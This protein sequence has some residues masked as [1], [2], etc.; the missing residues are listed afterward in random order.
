MATKETLENKIN[1]LIEEIE[2]SKVSEKDINS[3][4]ARI[5]KYF[6]DT[7]DTQDNFISKLKS[8]AGQQK[9]FVL[10]ANDFKLTGVIVDEET[11]TKCDADQAVELLKL[12]MNELNKPNKMQSLTIFNI[13]KCLNILI[14]FHKYNFTT[15]QQSVQTESWRVLYTIL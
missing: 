6:N 5:S 14:K 2:N 10:N 8:F 9:L 3:L 12:V 13:G 1:K 15:H 4:R 11:L 7:D